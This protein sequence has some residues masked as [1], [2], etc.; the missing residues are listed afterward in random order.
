[1]GIKD[2]AY[3]SLFDKKDL[4]YLY[5]LAEEVRA[6]HNQQLVDDFNN[7]CQKKW[8][9]HNPIL[10]VGNKRIEFMQV[11]KADDLIV[12]TGITNI[13]D[14][15]LGATV[16]RWLYISVGTG[17]TAPV[18]GQTALTAIWS[19]IDMSLLGWRENAGTTLKFAGVFGETKISATITESGVFMPSSG[20][21]LNRN[22]YTF[23]P[24][25]HVL[26]ASAFVISSVIEFVP[27]V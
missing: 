11:S 15:I 10:E 5:R 19:T 20:P 2:T 17:S 18:I 6:T 14:Q 25:S 22:V 12:T 9:D 24:I 13:I 7:K 27:V 26:N 3:A 1:M 23:N 8:N 4:P 21:M 16:V